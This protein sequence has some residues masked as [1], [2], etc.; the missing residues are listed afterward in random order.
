MAIV[1]LVLLKP[2]KIVFN[3]SNAEATFIQSTRTHWFLKTIQTLSCWYSLGSSQ[4][5]LSDEHPH[6]RVSVIFSFVCIIQCC[7]ISNQQHE[8]YVG[9]IGEAVL[10]VRANL[11]EELPCL[12]KQAF[13]WSLQFIKVVRISVLDRPFSLINIIPQNSQ[14]QVC[15]NDI[16]EKKYLKKWIKNFSHP[17]KWINEDVSL[18]QWRVSF[19]K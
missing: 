1:I 6:A 5:V 17:L 7:K 14:W 12:E 15:F 13:V 4:R 8:G 2:T 3:P 11:R 18:T 19:L 9:S 10:Q 16:Y